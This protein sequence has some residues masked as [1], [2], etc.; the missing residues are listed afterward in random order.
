ML[1]KRVNGKLRTEKKKKWINWDCYCCFEYCW[2]KLLEHLGGEVREW[3][4]EEKVVNFH[5]SFSLT[6]FHIFICL[7]HVKDFFCHKIKFHCCLYVYL[8]F[9]NNSLIV[10]KHE[11]HKKRTEQ[12][13]IHSKRTKNFY[14]LR[15]CKKKQ[16]N[17]WIIMKILLLQ[18]PWFE[19]DDK[20]NF[21]KKITFDFCVQCERTFMEFIDKK[22]GVE[23]IV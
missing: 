3:I 7:K 6:Y 9:G 4:K 2:N 5:A 15:S 23:V 18:L 21:H 1:A 12:K 16:K 17:F 13:Q 14:F 19:G 11:T 10:T 8:Y 20:E 22:S